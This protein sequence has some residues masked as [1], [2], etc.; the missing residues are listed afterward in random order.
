MII[1]LMKAGVSEG[2]LRGQIVSTSGI[3]GLPGHFN[4]LLCVRDT[5]AAMTTCDNRWGGAE[6]QGSR[7][8][9]M[10]TGRERALL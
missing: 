4:T 5:K 2:F 10:W 7:H 8:H 9:W 1:T 6:F 3:L